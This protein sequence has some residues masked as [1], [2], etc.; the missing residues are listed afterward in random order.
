MN[1]AINISPHEQLQKNI[2]HIFQFISNKHT[3]KLIYAVIAIY[4]M[5]Y[6]ITNLVLLCSHVPFTIS[7]H[8]LNC[9]DV[10]TTNYKDSI[11]FII[12]LLFQFVVTNGTNLTGY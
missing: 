8:L 9:Y 1:T 11:I 7:D 3:S 4:I 2:T 12:N 10:N 6:I 5:A